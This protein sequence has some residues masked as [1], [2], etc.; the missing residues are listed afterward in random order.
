[1]STAPAL[2]RRLIPAAV[3]MVL[4]G[5]L[6]CAGLARMTNYGVVAAPQ[7]ALASVSLTF[8]DLPNGGVAVRDAATGGL[9]ANVAARDDGFLRMVIRLMSANRQ[10]NNIGPAA[11]YILTEFSGG[12]MRLTDQATGQ[13]IELEAFGHSNIAEFSSFLS[14]ETHS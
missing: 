12:R 14:P 4:T 11:P 3:G 7:T 8:A 1:M 13:Q 2:P 9:I 10:R 5:T 6:L